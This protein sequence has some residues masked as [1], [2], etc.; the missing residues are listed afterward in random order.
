M[1]SLALDKKESLVRDQTCFRNPNGL[2][3]IKRLCDKFVFGDSF[4]DCLYAHVKVMENKEPEHLECTDCQ[5]SEKNPRKI[6]NA[7]Q[8]AKG[9]RRP[10]H[11]NNEKICSNGRDVHEVTG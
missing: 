3:E 11:P 9:K 1:K 10:V 2:F 5:N 6:S 7:P 8:S 4:L